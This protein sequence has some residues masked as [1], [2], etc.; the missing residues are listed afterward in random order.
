[1]VEKILFW[2]NFRNGNFD[3]FTAYEI[4]KKHLK[5][6]ILALGL[7]NRVSASV[8]SIT[9]KLIT[10]ETSNFGFYICIIDKRYL[11]FFYKNRTKIVSTGARKIILLH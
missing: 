3:G 10:A 2:V 7:H 9:Q 5:I 6:T 4:T 1:M 11:K 8:I